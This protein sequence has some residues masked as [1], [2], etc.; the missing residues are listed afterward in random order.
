VFHRQ[1]KGG[2]SYISA[3]DPRVLVGL[4]E[5]ERVDFVLVRWPSGARSKLSGP[6]SRRTHVLHE[7]DPAGSDGSRDRARDRKRSAGPG[8]RPTSAKDIPSPEGQP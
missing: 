2:G 5:C 6:A 1:V 8:G 3:N 7:P 4:G